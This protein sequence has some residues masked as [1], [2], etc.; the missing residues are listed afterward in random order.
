MIKITA[1]IHNLVCMSNFR[2]VVR[3]CAASRVVLADFGQVRP[4]GRYLTYSL[5]ILS[6]IAG[7]RAWQIPVCFCRIMPRDTFFI[8]EQLKICFYVRLL[9]ARV[10]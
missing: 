8:F 6:V 5:G 10:H 7:L 3:E 1:K 9:S 2:H 4:N